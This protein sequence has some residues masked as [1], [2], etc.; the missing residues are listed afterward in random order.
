MEYVNISALLT[1]YI[2]DCNSPQ[3][4]GTHEFILISGATNVIQERSKKNT[5]GATTCVLLLG[6]LLE[7]DPVDTN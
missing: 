3:N 5:K 6:L 4:D 1:D 2:I 7:E